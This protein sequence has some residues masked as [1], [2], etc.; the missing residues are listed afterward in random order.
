MVLNFMFIIIITVVILEILLISSIRQNY[1]KSLENTL[2]NQLQ[3]SS[4]LYV[5]YFSDATLHE[6]V[7]NNVDT[8]WKRVT[9][10]VQIIDLDGNVLMNS[11]GVLDDNTSK[12]EDVQNALQGNPGK[13]IGKVSYDTEKVMAVSYPLIV[14]E[15]P[16]GVL[17]FI[18]SL[19]EI[20]KEIRR[21]AYNFVIFGFVVILIAGFVSILLSNTIIG[22]LK[23][24]TIVAEEMAK[25]NFNAKSKKK[26]NDE[27]GKLSDTLNYM[28]N[29]I[30]KKD[31][32]K[33]DF[34][35]SVSHELRTPLTSIKGWAITLKEEST[36]KEILKDGLDI[37]QKESDRLSDMVEELLD[38]SKFSSGKITLKRSELYI[39]N[40]LNHIQTQ[41]LP[42]ALREKKEFF[43]TYGKENPSIYMDEN[44][45]KQV[46]INL[47]D[48]AF[49]FTDIGGEVSLTSTYFQNNY[50][51]IIKD[52]GCG[53]PKDEL[54]KVKEKFYK[55]NSS[56]SQN[57]IGLSISDEII[58]M[59]NGT[60]EI[61]SKV[62]N[63]TEI[64]VTLPVE[65]V[66][67]QDEKI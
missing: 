38:F 30:I 2:L 17:R 58:S 23:E 15:K 61:K 1:Y 5:R 53:I 29:E 43:I 39:P 20:N 24:I 36:S 22:P 55:G 26:T 45:L 12:A 42:R 19:K 60:L 54:P 49:K 65:E 59:M 11:I 10:Q 37:I 28:A 4:D 9:A 34:I 67:K 8:F 40:I 48:N 13:W 31:E 56:K 27:I 7:L 51:F 14:E 32:L 21:I 16:I 18:A 44:R 25:G 50:F 46:F 62:N 64:I 57:G 3:V 33:N 6:N 47:L 35:S 52:N 63:G 66:S 41:L